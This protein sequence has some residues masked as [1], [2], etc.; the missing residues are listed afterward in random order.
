MRT[1]KQYK[2]VLRI[3][4]LVGK[5]KNYLESNEGKTQ[6]MWP[7]CRDTPIRVGSCTVNPSDKLEVLGVFFDKLLLPT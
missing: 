4:W 2:E 1:Q 5:E 3:L 7:L 6:V